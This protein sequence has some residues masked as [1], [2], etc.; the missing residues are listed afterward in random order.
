M[1]PFG[2][3]SSVRTARVPV[4]S[5]GHNQRGATLW[6]RDRDTAALERCGICA[7]VVADGGGPVS[8]RL[9]NMRPKIFCTSS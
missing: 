7:L 9:R 3:I 2:H 1:A 5:L 6:G 4:H 8:V